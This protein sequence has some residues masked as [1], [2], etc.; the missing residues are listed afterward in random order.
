MFIDSSPESSGLMVDRLFWEAYL[1]LKRV[2]FTPDKRVPDLLDLV[3]AIVV[4]R[5]EAAVFLR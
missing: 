1:L 3:K 4:R 2:S 5:L